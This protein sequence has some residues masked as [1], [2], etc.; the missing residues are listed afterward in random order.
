MEKCILKNYTPSQSCGSERGFYVVSVVVSV[1][2]SE[3]MRG[4][5]VNNLS[6][7]GRVCLQGWCRRPEPSLYRKVQRPTERPAFDR[8]AFLSRRG[9]LGDISRGLVV[10]CH[11]ALPPCFLQG[12][13]RHL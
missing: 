5:A 9:H 13:T 10:T 2:A 7:L 6:A 11:V 3:R 1:L 4:P 8:E 12:G